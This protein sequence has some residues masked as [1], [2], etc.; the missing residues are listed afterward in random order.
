[1]SAEADLAWLSS[2]PEWVRQQNEREAMADER[3][4]QELER[5]RQAQNC[6][7]FGH[8]GTPCTRCGDNPDE[9][10]FRRILP[11]GVTPADYEE[12]FSRMNR[13][14]MIMRIALV[15]APDQ[16]QSPDGTYLIAFTCGICGAVVDWR[17][18]HD[19]LFHHGAP[20]DL[21]PLL[22]AEQKHFAGIK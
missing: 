8:I 15:V 10:P 14:W 17:G 21:I 19:H 18:D 6:R 4:R 12:L 16:A 9:V 13:P 5:Q 2:D 3:R 22:V 1:M 11:V 7:L 20:T